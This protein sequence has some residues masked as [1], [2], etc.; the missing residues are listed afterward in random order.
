MP[1][2]DVLAPP[3][4]PSMIT[5]RGSLY[6]RSVGAAEERKWFIILALPD[7]IPGYNDLEVEDSHGGARDSNTIAPGAHPLQ[8][9]SARTCQGP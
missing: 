9:P 8:L 3:T 2:S 4:S 5:Q 7:A 1:T 6:H